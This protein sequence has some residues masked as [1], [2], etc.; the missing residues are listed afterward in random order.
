MSPVTNYDIVKDRYC[1]HKYSCGVWEE[2]S[3]ISEIGIGIKRKRRSKNGNR[4]SERREEKPGRN[5]TKNEVVEKAKLERNSEKER[6]IRKEIIKTSFC[7]TEQSRMPA[8][9]HGET[10]TVVVAQ[11]EVCG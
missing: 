8:F 5:V 7:G 2:E 3:W 10:S 1:V 6:K 9:S 11:F 4:T